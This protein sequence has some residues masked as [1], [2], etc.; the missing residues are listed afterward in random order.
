V[1]VR[2]E[3]STSCAEQACCSGAFVAAPDAAAAALIINS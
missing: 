3:R 1:Q 2:K